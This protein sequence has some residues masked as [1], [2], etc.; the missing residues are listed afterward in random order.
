MLRLLLISA[1]A[2]VVLSACGADRGSD[3]GGVLRGGGVSAFEAELRRAE[4][5]PVVVNQWASWCS[6]CK[7]EFPLLRD[8]ARDLEGKVRFLGVNSRDARQDAEAFLAKE[9][10]GF[11]HFDDPDAKIARAMR[12]GRSWPST[13]FY[14]ATGELVYTHQ[15]A[16]RTAKDLL[17]D[18]DRYAR[19]G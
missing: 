4:G 17:E 16:Y 18:I 1:A 5:I 6:P 19:G 10:T 3:S 12:A 8:V 15:G 2:V 11:P 13:A 14:D 7:A 9:P